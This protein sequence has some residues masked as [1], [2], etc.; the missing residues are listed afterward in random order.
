MER[1]RLRENTPRMRGGRGMN[2][3]VLLVEDDP[4]Y[5]LSIKLLFTG[6]PYEFVEAE[7][8]E[9]GIDKLTSNPEIRVILLDLSFV[10]GEG[11]LV[12]DHLKERAGDYKVIV[13]TAHDELLRAERAGEYSVFNYLPKAERSSTQAIR[14]SI[15]QAFNDLEREHLDRKSRY[16]LEVQKR[17]ND[18][19]PTRE[20]LDLICRSVRSTVGAYTCHIRVYDL[21]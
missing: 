11:T 9:E 20:T 2:K 21:K 5:R 19:R 1:R 14:F 18:N 16:L 4:H 13:L 17:I 8:P 7:S 12:L 10:H 3:Q 6:E 15:E